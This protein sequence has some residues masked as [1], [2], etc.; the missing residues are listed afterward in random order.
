MSVNIEYCD[1]FSNDPHDIWMKLEHSGRYLFAYNF[2]KQQGC[3]TVIDIAAANGYGSMLLTENGMKVFAADRNKEYLDSEHIRYHRI[4]KACFDFDKDEMSQ[5]LPVAD[6]VVCFETIEH[7]RLP[8]RFL[9][10][11]TA[12]I[13]VNGWLLLSFPNARYERFNEDGTN[14]DPF[15]LHVLDKDEVISHLTGLDYE[16]I[17]VLGQPLCNEICSMQH[18][19]KEAGEITAAEIDDSFHYDIRSIKALSRLL[20]YPCDIRIDNSYSVIIIARKKS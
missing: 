7:L 12:Q 2:L 11:I 18:D 13:N 20:A 6:A 14:R 5:Y 4:E 15:H 10:N 19:L 9:D 1:P 8:F 16:I 3:H 17:S